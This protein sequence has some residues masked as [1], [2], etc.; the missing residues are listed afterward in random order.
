[1]VAPRRVEPPGGQLSLFT[2]YLEHPAVAQLRELKLEAM[3]PMQA[4]DTLRRL[5]ELSDGER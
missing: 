3:T 5:L 2:E 1:M 4:F